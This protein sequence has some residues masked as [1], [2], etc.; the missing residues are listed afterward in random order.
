MYGMPVIETRT[1]TTEAQA[2]QIGREIGYPLV[3][4]LQSVDIPHKTEAGGVLL[5]LRSDPDVCTAFG[6]I[7]SSARHYKPDA[8]LDG[9]TIQPYF[10]KSD[11]ELLLGAKR[12]PNF[13]PVILFGMGG[14]YT[15][16]LKDRSLGLPPM[17]RLLAKRLMQGTR[18]YTLLKGY[19]NRLPTD[20]GKLEEIIIRLSQLLIDF[21]QISELDMNPILVKDS[22][23]IAVD[24]RILVSPTKIP[25]PLHLVISPYPAED[26]F[27]METVDG[28]A[29][30]IRPVRPEDA[31]LFTTLFKELSP[32]T[33]Y[34]RFFSAV[35]ELN[36]RM[37][38]R[39]TQIDYDREIALVAIN[40]TSKTDRMLGVARIIGD[41]DSKT[42]EFAVLVGDD[43]HGKGIGVCLLRKCLSIAEKRGFR[44]IHGFV[45]KANRNAGAWEKAWI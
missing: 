34:N 21:P 15:E 23:P 45:L 4:K 11:F 16:V 12:D 1:A 26:E 10:S 9:V 31:P 35:K 44:M 30:F 36:P 39:F 43:W 27:H 28:Q 17:N 19:R 8:R 2:S 3:M 42:G 24:A 40:E 20:L 18:V 41:S 38:A 5:D 6:Q 25:S 7:M 13:G 32:T 14:I 22:S 33:I 37:L 29:L